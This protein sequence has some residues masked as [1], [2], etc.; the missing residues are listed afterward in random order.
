LLPKSRAP[1]REGT[2]DNQQQGERKPLKKIKCCP[3][4]NNHQ[5]DQILQPERRK[6]NRAKNKGKSIQIKE[7]LNQIRI[8]KGKEEENQ[9]GNLL[10]NTRSLF[11]DQAT[12]PATWPRPPP[13]TQ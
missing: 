5:P 3:S 6:S 12:S 7:D 4:P 1:S 8:K 2:K 10:V 9:S 13:T 11:Q